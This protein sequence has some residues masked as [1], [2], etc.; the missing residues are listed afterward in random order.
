M[1]TRT[2]DLLQSG[3]FC[4]C[5]DCPLLYCQF[6]EALRGINGRHPSDPYPPYNGMAQIAFGTK[7]HCLTI[8][9]PTRLHASTRAP[10]SLNWLGA[11]YHISEDTLNAGH[12][13]DKFDGSCLDSSAK[14]KSELVGQAIFEPHLLFEI[15]I[16]VMLLGQLMSLKKKLSNRST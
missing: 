10:M 15:L 13:R 6:S 3:P 12:L 4:L 5:L 8:N 11:N 1:C 9:L 7:E 16:S 2:F 14:G